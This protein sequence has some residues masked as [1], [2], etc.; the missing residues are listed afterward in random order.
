MMWKHE[1]MNVLNAVDDDVSERTTKIGN[2]YWKLV[3]NLR[4]YGVSFDIG[5]GTVE[6]QD[7]NYPLWRRYI[8]ISNVFP[9][10]RTICEAE[11]DVY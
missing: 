5:A 8:V 4:T 10:F 3:S 6:V 11:F 1:W 9:F 7:T 2:V